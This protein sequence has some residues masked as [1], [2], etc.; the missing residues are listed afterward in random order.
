LTSATEATGSK[1]CLAEIARVGA[2]RI[3]FKFFVRVLLCTNL[4][5][6]QGIVHIHLQS[7]FKR[8]SAGTDRNGKCEEHSRL[9]GGNV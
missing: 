1:A 3:I 8:R 9:H 5:Q 2:L 4:Q 6:M 7:C